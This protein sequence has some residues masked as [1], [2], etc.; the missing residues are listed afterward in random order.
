MSFKI[1][2][3][4]FMIFASLIENYAVKMYFA[5]AKCKLKPRAVVWENPKQ[6]E[7]EKTL[8]FHTF[9]N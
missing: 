6:T 7:N 8:D 2:P 9:C 3:L 5:V 1:C 4:F